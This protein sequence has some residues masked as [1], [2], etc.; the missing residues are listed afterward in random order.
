MEVRRGDVILV[1]FKPVEGSEID[2]ERPAIV[3]QNDYG[4]SNGGSCTIVVACSS[5]KFNSR[6]HFHVDIYENNSPM[7][8]NTA[9]L[10]DQIRTIDVEERANF[11]IGSLSEGYMDKIDTKLKMMLSLD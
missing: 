2:K 6:F 7:D 11:K 3:V 5:S 1:D 4:N 9:A 10:V 8:N